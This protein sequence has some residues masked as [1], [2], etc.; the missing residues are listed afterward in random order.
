MI[1]GLY[2]RSAH[3]LPE[4]AAC[5]LGLTLSHQRLCDG[6]YPTVRGRRQFGAGAVSGSRPIEAQA[7]RFVP[8]NKGGT[9]A[10]APWSHSSIWQMPWVNARPVPNWL[11]VKHFCSEVKVRI[12]D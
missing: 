9:N 6:H 8:R 5:L 3:T 4:L 1:F 2:G 7:A 12:G 10:V 11:R